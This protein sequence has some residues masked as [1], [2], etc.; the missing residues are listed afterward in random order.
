MKKEKP[1]V[2]NKK[3]VLTNDELQSRLKGLYLALGL[4]IDNRDHMSK[5]NYSVRSNKEFGVFDVRIKVLEPLGNLYGDVIWNFLDYMVEN[6]VNVA[7][8]IDYYEVDPSGRKR[9]FRGDI[10]WNNL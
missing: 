7:F 10:D 4:D 8:T 9:T 3:G 2:N 5:L 1:M 6:F